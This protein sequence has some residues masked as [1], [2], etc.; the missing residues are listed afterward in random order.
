MGENIAT[1]EGTVNALDGA[2]VRHREVTTVM[3][4][5]I[6]VVVGMLTPAT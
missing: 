6:V 3:R 2:N 5:K 1:T 4:T